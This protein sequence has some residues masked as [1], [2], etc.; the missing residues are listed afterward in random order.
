MRK[1]LKKKIDKG[2]RLQNSNQVGKGYG[3]K[4]SWEIRRE[5]YGCHH[6]L[7]KEILK[8]S[9]YNINYSLMNII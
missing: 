5:S 1:E 2:I 7:L 3:N 8:W 9:C 4:N 6:I